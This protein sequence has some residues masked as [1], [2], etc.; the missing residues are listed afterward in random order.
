MQQCP[1]AQGLQSAKVEIRRSFLDVS[2]CIVHRDGVEL[3]RACLASLLKQPQGVALE[4]IVVDN[5]SADD[6]AGMVAREFPEVVLIRNRVN[7][8]FACGNNQAAARASGR[9]LFFLNNDTVAPPFALG[10]LLAW[11]EA[12]PEVG[13][14]GPRLRDGEGNVQVSYRSRPTLA[15]LLHRT[16]LLRWTGLLRCLYQRHR[17]Q[18]FDPWTTRPVEVLMGAA[19]LIRRDR[20]F[21]WGRWN[22]E[23]PFGGEDLELCARVHRFAPIIYLPAVEITHYG[24]VSTRRHAGP[25]GA[26]IAFGFARYLRHSGV[27]RLGLL[28]YK[29]AVTLD[30]PLQILSKGLEYLLRRLR[31]QHLKAHK[32]ARAVRASAYFLVKGLVPFW[33][34]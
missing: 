3:L 23:F 9:Y 17:R 20:F 26:A 24:R 15:T 1:E 2:V 34:A 18:Q 22:E 4:V 14:I 21:A 13:L 28:A 7:R 27:S 10:Q 8:G 29:L 16:A 25:A 32:S 6:S 33:R 19:L 30:A 31:G 5:G 12:H 11:A